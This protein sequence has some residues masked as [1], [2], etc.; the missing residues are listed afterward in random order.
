MSLN[1]ASLSAGRLVPLKVRTQPP[2]AAI[3]AAT[4]AWKAALLDNTTSTPLPPELAELLLTVVFAGVATVEVISSDGSS[5]D[6]Y[7]LLV[8]FNM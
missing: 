6:M 3:A 4:A 7:H 1:S 2:A 8:P 5:G